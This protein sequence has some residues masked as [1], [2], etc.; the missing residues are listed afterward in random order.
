PLVRVP[1][2]AWV[3]GGLGV[4]MIVLMAAGITLLFKLTGSDVRT[5]PAGRFERAAPPPMYVD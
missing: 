2:Q 5:D 3:F 1:R 4:L